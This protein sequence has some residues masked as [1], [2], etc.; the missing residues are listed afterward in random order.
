M[1]VV[2][3]LT[4]S[5]SP[6]QLTYVSKKLSSVTGKCANLWQVVDVHICLIDE[7]RLPT[8]HMLVVT[9]ILFPCIASILIH[10]PA[11]HR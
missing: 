1:S 9:L 10:A 8:T 2:G 3:R 5:T 6:G 7:G 11:W 4:T